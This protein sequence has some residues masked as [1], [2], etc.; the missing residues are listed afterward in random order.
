MIPS[1]KRL[2]CG[3]LL[4]AAASGTA[5]AQWLNYKSSDVPRTRDGKPKLDARAP[6][7]VDGHPDL[8]GV[9]MHDFTPM[10]ELKRLFGP[11]IEGEEATEIPGMEAGNIHK[12]ALSVLADFPSDESPARPE[13]RKIVEARLKNPPPT[14]LCTP[15]SAPGPFPLI[16]LLSEP[17]KIVQAPKQTLVLYE[18]GS[19]FRQIYTDGRTPLTTINLPAFFGYSAGHWERDTFI[20]DTTGFN[21]K[22]PLDGIGNPHSDQLRIIERYRRPDF[23][24]LLVEMTYDDPQ[25]YTR[26]FTIKFSYHLLADAD[27]FEMHDENERDCAR[28]EALDKR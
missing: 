5:H 1:L 16:G 8:T 10:D 15:S 2:A 3:C 18:I 28:I 24:H 14:D 12:Y 20:V 6:R 9:W 11:L 23:G 17:I 25:M 27:I 21:D 13:A 26:P 7:F 22:N 19:D 4:A